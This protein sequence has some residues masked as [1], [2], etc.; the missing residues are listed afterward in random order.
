MYERFDIL[1][2]RVFLLGQGEVGESLRRYDSETGSVAA[3]ADYLR[4]IDSTIAT[5]DPA[6]TATIEEIEQRL[7][8]FQ[9]SCASTRCASC[10]PTA[11]PAPGFA[12]ASRAA[13]EPRR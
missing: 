9:Q 3:L 8:D 2:S 1:W 5:L 7:H 6:D 12:T 11:P 10:A 13:P 4:A